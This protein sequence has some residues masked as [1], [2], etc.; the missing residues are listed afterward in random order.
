MAGTIK[1]ARAIKPL[2]YA[3]EVLGGDLLSDCKFADVIALSATPGTEATWTVPAT[4]KLLRITCK[5][6]FWF[7]FSGSAITVPAASTATGDAPALCVF[8]VILECVPGDVLRCISSVASA[9]ISIE[10][11]S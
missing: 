8:P 1:P 9:L 7:K 5:D 4:A 2:N 11:W 6:P 3:C 10:V